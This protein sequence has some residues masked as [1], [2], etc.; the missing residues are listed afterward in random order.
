M[1]VNQPKPS[2]EEPTTQPFPEQEENE[3]LEAEGQQQEPRSGV[4]GAGTG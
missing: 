4:H 3:P 2:D 1:S